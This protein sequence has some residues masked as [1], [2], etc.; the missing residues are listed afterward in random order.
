MR[1]LVDTNIVIWAMREDE[2]LGPVWQSILVDPRNE[3]FLSAASV[4]E[5][6]IKLGLGKLTLPD[7]FDEG[8]QQFG[9]RELAVSWE[10]ARVTGGLPP[11]HKDPFDR[12]LVAQAIS[13]R[14]VLITGDATLRG[15]GD[16][17][18]VV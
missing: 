3:L 12:L 15:Y 5:M 9:F 6:K 16:F 1:F 13:E 4:W 11:I 2:R 18:S 10:H 17:V 8:L 14:L 7:G